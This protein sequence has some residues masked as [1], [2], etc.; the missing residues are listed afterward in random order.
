MFLIFIKCE[1]VNNVIL[2][3]IAEEHT[4]YLTNYLCK[5][6]ILNDEHIDTLMYKTKWVGAIILFYINNTIL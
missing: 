5:T 2:S 1:T 4:V 6:K 3:P